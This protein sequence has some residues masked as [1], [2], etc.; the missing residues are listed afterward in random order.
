AV[1]AEAVSLAVADASG[2]PVAT[3][4][5]LVLRAFSP[6]QLAAQG[7]HDA[8]F[9]PEWTPVSLPVSAPDGV[10]GVLGGD[11]LGLA[12]AIAFADLADAAEG[13]VVPDILVVALPAA[14]DPAAAAA[15]HAAVRDVLALV[16]E[17]LAADA[18]AD[19]RLVVVTRKSAGAG[20]GDLPAAAVRGLLRSAQSEHPGRITV[21]DVDGDPASLR[22][23]SCALGSDEP[24]LVLRAGSAT[25]LRLLRVTETAAPGTDGTDALG[26]GTVLLTGAT[27]ALG[28]QVARHLVAERGVRRLLLVSRRGEA[29]PG[30]VELA[31]DLAALGAETAFAACDAADRDALARR[32]DGTDLT[33]VVHIAGV[34]DDGIITSL[35][36][37]RLAAVL[38]PKVDAAWN[39]H[40]LTK[41]RPLAAFVLFSSLAGVFGAAGQANYA[42]ANSFLDAL[43]EHRHAAGLPAASLAWGLWADDGGMA[44]TLAGADVERMA[45]GG[46]AAL[47]VAEGLALL[48]TATALPHHPVLVPARLDLATVRAAAAQGGQVPALLRSLVPPPVRRAA[49]AAEADPAADLRRR[50]AGQSA[51]DRER[52][53]LDVVCGQVAAVLGYAGA[54]AV[55]PGHAFRELGF[56][57][58]TAV[59]LRN[60]LTAVTGLRLPA[61]LIFDHPSPA[62]L[63][64][65]LSAA[66]PQDGDPAGPGVFAEL[67]RLA[68]ALAGTPTDAETGARVTLRL[69][70]LLTQWRDALSGPA[71]PVDDHRDL[72]TATD[73]ELFDLLDDE[74]ETS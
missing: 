11:D 73:D 52:I 18:F 9:R 58:L 28:R 7:G 53:L 20:A 17:W 31:A 68:E 66:V 72:D 61:T 57:S 16:Q 46:V 3:V 29:A 6:E 70:A 67:D 22:A 60:R 13:G 54:A 50:L 2:A 64:A 35:T 47:S 39:L 33:A 32:L 26:G 41:D 12:G 56:D 4:D 40:E 30:A 62:D 24:Q 36:P 38:R 25:A 63:V 37:E 45:R 10:I 69:Q 74:L 51:Q 55:Q 65:H 19:S 49:R 1:G 15:T 14:E 42:A 43:S 34:L 8:L 71:D 5:S 21:V 48:D 23:L 44:D 27:G 59:E